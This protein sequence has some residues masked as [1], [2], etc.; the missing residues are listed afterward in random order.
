MRRVVCFSNLRISVKCA[1][2]G[3][4]SCICK[5]FKKK[6]CRSSFVR[7]PESCG[8]IVNVCSKT[9]CQMNIVLLLITGPLLSHSVHLLLHPPSPLSPE[10]PQLAAAL[11][12]WSPGGNQSCSRHRAKCEPL[13]SKPQF[14]NEMCR[15]LLES[16]FA[17][18][19]LF[20][21][22]S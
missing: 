22:Y 20:Y 18:P 19:N 10:S 13:K 5:L 12:P 6:D 17:N 14:P 15:T 16:I 4:P 2:C 21:N 7:C 1:C 8:N 11:Q 3:R 9:C